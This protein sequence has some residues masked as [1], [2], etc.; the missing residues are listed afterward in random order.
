M[1]SG[2]LDEYFV[3]DGFELLY[4]LIWVENES[5]TRFEFFRNLSHR[6]CVDDKLLFLLEHQVSRCQNPP[7]SSFTLLVRL[8]RAEIKNDNVPQAQDHVRGEVVRIET[9]H[10]L[11]DQELHRKSIFL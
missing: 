3:D 4:E 7:Y 5:R 9:G 2:T 10:A 8:S 11:V 6:G 1:H